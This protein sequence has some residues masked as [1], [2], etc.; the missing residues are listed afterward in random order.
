MTV[1]DHLSQHEAAESLP[2]VTD[3]ARVTH[4]E[5]MDD[6]R[7]EAVRDAVADC[8]R[9][10]GED[11]WV[12]EGTGDRETD[13]YDVDWDAVEAFAEEEGNDVLADLLARFD[14]PYP[15]LM[16][17]RVDPETDLEFAAGQYVTLAFDGTPRPYSVANSPDEDEIEFCIRRVPGGHLTSNL[18]TKLN[19]D[20]RVTVRGPNGEFVLQEPSGRDMVFL[21]TGTG[22]AP[23]KSMIEYT[24]SQGRDEVDGEQRDVW[25]FLGCGWADDLPYH[26][27]FQRLDAD[28]ENFHYV[29]TLSRESHLTD[30]DGESDYVQQVLMKYVESDADTSLD[31][32]LEAFLDEAPV[33]DVDARIDPA[34]VEVYACG[35]TAMVNT[36]VA[37]VEQL[38]VDEQAIEAEG[39][40]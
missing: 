7:T 17:V 29:P 35:I 31:G 14:R 19:V 27:A 36:L 12:H 23:L 38:G 25:L 5:A 22:V 26:D 37:A 8:L 30:W 15:S 1:R 3:G 28:H 34:N 40:G 10:H 33:Y 20:D 13:G 4:V 6:N 32:G 39:F 24:L 18:F 9:A 2:L 11:Q 21:A 16:R